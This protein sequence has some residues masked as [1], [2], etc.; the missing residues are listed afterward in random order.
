M[1]ELLMKHGY[2][3]LDSYHEWI[4]KNWT[5]RFTPLGV[6]AFNDPIVGELG[7]YY[8]S[9]YDEIDMNELLLEIDRIM[10]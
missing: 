10:K 4:K 7:R 3:K 1:E 9:T 6:E 5:I 2:V 8:S